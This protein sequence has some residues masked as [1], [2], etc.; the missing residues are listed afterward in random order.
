LRGNFSSLLTN[1][2]C[3]ETQHPEIRL[4]SEKTTQP[5]LFARSKCVMLNTGCHE[6][7]I[8]AACD[9]QNDHLELWH[10]KRVYSNGYLS[11]DV[12]Q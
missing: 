5:G 12:E 8:A 7:R 4:F 6:K 2:A 10:I 9:P 11:P 3:P 1:Q